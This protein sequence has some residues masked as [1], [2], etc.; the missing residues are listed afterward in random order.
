MKKNTYTVGD[1]LIPLT[2]QMVRDK[3]RIRNTNKYQRIEHFSPQ[4]DADRLRIIEV[5]KKKG[6]IVLTLQEEF[7]KLPY[8]DY[9]IRTLTEEVG[10]FT[11]TGD[12][13]GETI[14]KN[15]L[16]GKEPGPYLN[17]ATEPLYYLLGK[18]ETEFEDE[19]ESQVQ[20]AADPVNVL[21]Y[22]AVGSCSLWVLK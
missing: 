6:I 2:V 10:Y 1:Y 14:Q 16:Q 11:P 8:E 5:K 21:T 3:Y 20:V 19:E 22:N 12:L 17:G 18:V 15:W 7:D 4:T 9:E 13:E